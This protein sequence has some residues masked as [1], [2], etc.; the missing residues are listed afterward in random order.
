MSYE[1]TNW[2]SGD[3]V[4]SAKLNKMESGIENAGAL[5]VMEQNDTLDKTWAEIREAVISGRGVV[6]LK[7]QDSEPLDTSNYIRIS[8]LTTVGFDGDVYYVSFFVGDDK[9]DYIAQ[10]EDGVLT[11]DSDE[12]D[13]APSA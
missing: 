3:V 4:T 13:E 11:Y 2:K 8:T 7:A 12:G 1:P 5:I 10:S 6:L 9:Y